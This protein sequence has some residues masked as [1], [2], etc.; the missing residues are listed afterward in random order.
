M[1]EEAG[2]LR[3]VGSFEFLEEACVVFGEHAEVFHLIFQ[4]G[5][6][7]HAHSEGIS[8]VFL[9]V[10]A[11]ILQYGRIYHAATEYFH[12]S[13]AFAEGASLAAADVA[14]DVHFGRWFREGK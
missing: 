1:M 14:A 6:S 8:A 3:L 13:R 4:V 7:L 2:G 10:D 12:P 11:V 9:A 5:D